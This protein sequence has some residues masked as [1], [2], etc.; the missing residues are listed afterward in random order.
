[1][2]KQGKCVNIE[3][4]HYKEVFDIQAGE[5]FECPFCHKP[6]AE[7][8][9][10]KKHKD[11][12][13]P[14]KKLMELIAAAVAL[15]AGLGGGVYAL[16]SGSDNNKIQEEPDQPKLSV[17]MSIN[18]TEKALKVGETD[19]LAVLLNPDTIPATMVWSTQQDSA[20]VEVDNGIVKATK[21]GE[22][23]VIVK[24][25]LPNDTLEAQC[26]YKVEKAEEPKPVI[27]ETEQKKAEPV[28]PKKDVKKDTGGTSTGSSSNG[29]LHLSYGTY[30]GEIKNGHPDGIGRLTYNRS[31]RIN[32]YDDKGRVADAGDY[33]V[34]EF[35]RGFFVQGK[36]FG[37][38]GALK[39]S[40][41]I[42][43]QPGNDYESK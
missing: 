28:A 25:I 18:H 39:E 30:K 13:G 2:A 16:L 41:M 1:M 20:V 19:T 23:Q 24:T 17:E 29:T 8:T 21:E 5:E 35:V 15:L 38:D 42:G 43:V 27:E 7:S 37:G 31:R 32:R 4:D 40:L 34:G 14:N 3:C 22:G 9:D 10:G 12:N 11:G 26:L 33:V 36:W 6:L